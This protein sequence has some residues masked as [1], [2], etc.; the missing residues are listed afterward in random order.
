M[1]CL[2]IS[3]LPGTDES[4]ICKYV[5]SI[6]NDFLIP[7]ADKVYGG[8]PD[9]KPILKSIEPDKDTYP[10]LYQQ[11]KT[12][13]S[14]DEKDQ[15]EVWR[16]VVKH[17]I[18]TISQFREKFYQMIKNME[19]QDLLKVYYSY[20]EE[21]LLDLLEG[22]VDLTKY[23]MLGYMLGIEK[24]TFLDVLTFIRL[25]FFVPIAEV[26]LG[27]FRENTLKYMMVYI[28][29]TTYRGF[30]RGSEEDKVLA[31]YY[32]DFLFPLIDK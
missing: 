1:Y 24:I 18:N 17:D 5:L 32:M 11:W 25:L 7:L 6:F 12:I 27:K 26:I 10:K 3:V 13:L 30:M 19:Y 22:M 4:E 21:F 14:L 31:K 29:W 23:R 16:R 15:V 8:Y 28:S 20:Y 9:S 2:P